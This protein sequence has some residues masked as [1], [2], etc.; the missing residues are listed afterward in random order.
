MTARATIF[1]G[2]LLA[3]GG[4]CDQNQN[5]GM[6]PDAGQ[7][8]DAG[9]QQGDLSTADMAPH[10]KRVFISS[11]TYNGDLKTAGGGQT[12]LEGG[13][14]LCQHLAEAAALDGVWKAWLSDSTTN[15]ID[16]ITEGPWY[17]L[18]YAGL[19]T[20]FPVYETYETKAFNNKAN[21][22]TVPLSGIRITEFGQEVYSRTGFIYVWTGT[23]GSATKAN[24]TCSNWSSSAASDHGLMGSPGD[25]YPVWTDEPA[26]QAAN[27]SHSDPLPCDEPQHLYC[28]EQ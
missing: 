10:P 12:G 7:A 24:D 20:G 21:L 22:T 23:T 14:K 11:L 26:W 17:I 28:F 2:L 1:L 19:G 27:G 9:S 13:D 15:A 25:A 8:S 5:V 18:T 6:N 3:L 16:R 4:G